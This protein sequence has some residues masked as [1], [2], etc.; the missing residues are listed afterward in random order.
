M[1]QRPLNS[2]RLSFRLDGATWGW[3]ALLLLAIGVYALGL[4]GQYNPTNGDEL[5][6]THIAR[7]TA[8]SNH[9]LPLVSELDHMRNT[10][11]PLLF[12]QAM[13]A[14]NW[15]QHWSLAALR[16]PS[17]VY[18]LL[19]AG[20]VA[21]SVQK[22][23]R[24][25]RTACLAACIYLAFFCT[26]RYGRTFLTSAPE[27]F[28][29]NLPMFW[30]LW[31]RLDSH[32]RPLGEGRGEGEPAWLNASW[33]THA[34]FGMALGLGLAYKSFA[35]IAPVATALWCAQLLSAPALNWRLVVQTTLKVSLSAALA[36]G[37]FALWFVLDPDPGAVWQEFVI[38][39][40]AGKMSSTQGY[41]HTALFGGGVSMW[42]Q[43]LAYTQNAG[44]LGFV[45]LGLMWLGLRQ[46]FRA[47]RQPNS[48]T[49]LSPALVILLVWLAVWL[50]VF[51]LPSQRSARYVIPAMPALAMLIALCW[52][53]I[54]RGWFWLTLLLCGLFIGVLGR[55]AWAAHDV[56]IGTG[57]ELMATLIAVATGLIVALSGGV[58]PAWTRACA[59][60]AC[61]V[62]YACF[63][64]TTAPLNGP[65]GQYASVVTDQLQQARVAVP[66]GF[67][68]QFERFQFLLPSNQFVP[69]DTQ[70]LAQLLADFDAVV[71][72]QS[73]PTELSP[74]CLPDCTVVGARWEIKGR[75]QSGEIN[76][77]NLWYPQTWLFRREWLVQR[78]SDVSGDVPH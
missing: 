15:G 38:G 36:L 31:Q 5:V 64:L 57:L 54:A 75:H 18:T 3:L 60:A 72:L 16:L 37:I 32:P 59:V 62:A 40:N 12:W 30:L 33:L 11:P 34:G 35:L 14:G 78:V 66:G 69:Y 49:R 7:L 46:G 77:S 53:R 39:E 9:W 55:I 13:V 1:R 61:I 67:N 4:G 10:K 19:I 45:V 50:V 17:L 41:W 51:T 76:L 44:L 26:Y 27:T 68:G 8:A 43:L 58:K 70:T 6:Y 71:W 20:A 47:W 23:T 48:K 65:D 24:N 29:L 28:W 25:W 73:A 22:I 52:E 74:P 2:L 42:A 63:G 56:G 21:W